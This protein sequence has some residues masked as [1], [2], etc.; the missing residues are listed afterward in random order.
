MSVSIGMPCL[1][2][3]NS[4][5]TNFNNGYVGIGTATPAN[6]LEVISE[7]TGL[8]M[9]C[10]YFVNGSSGANLRMMKGRGTYAAPLRARLNDVI[11]GY[12]A[13]PYYAAGDAD[14]ALV[15][16]TAANASFQFFCVESATATQRGVGFKLNLT[17]IASIIP[18]TRLQLYDD[19]TL[20]HYNIQNLPTAAAGLAAGDIWVDTTGGLNILKI[21]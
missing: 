9:A 12:N 2:R 13:F 15:A 16:A 20:L 3:I 7:T 5:G 11:T 8:G 14:A 19:G 10:R 21:V 4:A 17:P 18:A 1:W 6:I